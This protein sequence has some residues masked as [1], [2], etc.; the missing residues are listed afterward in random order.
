MTWLT[1][2]AAAV[3]LIVLAVLASC[4]LIGLWAAFG[5]MLREHRKQQQRQDENAPNHPSEGYF[6]AKVFEV[7]ARSIEE[8]CPHLPQVRETARYLREVSRSE[9]DERLEDFYARMKQT[10]AD[11]W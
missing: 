2:L 9:T 7:N 4:F 3:G 6:Q 5:G 1:H 11:E 10:A 8:R